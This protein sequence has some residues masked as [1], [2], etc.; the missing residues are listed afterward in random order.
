MNVHG[1][2]KLAA[3]KLAEAGWTTHEIAA[4]TGHHTLA[5]V[6]FLIP[7]ARTASGSPDAAMQRTQVTLQ[8]GEGAEIVILVD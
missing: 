7:R 2:R 3:V 6:E 1:L 4:V 8:S 5:M